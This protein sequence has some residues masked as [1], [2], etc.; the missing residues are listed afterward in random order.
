MSRSTTHTFTCPCGQVFSGQA[1]EYV[2]VAD[3]AHL[4]YV[5]LAGLINVST[6]PN[7]SR[8]AAISMPFVYSDPAYNLLAYVHPRADAPEDAR[9]LILEKLRDVYMDATKLH[10]QQDKDGESSGNNGG[11][12]VS[13]SASEAKDM[14]P[15]KVVFGLEQLGELINS[16]LSQEDRLGR[17]ALSTQSRSEAERGQFHDITRK[18]A[19]EMGCCIEVEDLPDEYT[20]WLYGSRRQVGALMRELAAR[21]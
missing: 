1:Y 8:R 11:R 19:T 12:V 5:V 15:L 7:C 20:V 16:E 21:G 6:C 17:L 4:R 10:E 13:L 18:L 3:D 9:L 2:N 14:P